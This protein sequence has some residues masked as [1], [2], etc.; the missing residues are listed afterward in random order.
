MSEF[1]L[2][3]LPWLPKPSFEL[4]AEIAAIEMQLNACNE[5]PTKASKALLKLRWLATHHLSVTESFRLERFLKKV[6]HHHWQASGLQTCRL[7]IVANSTTDLLLGPLKIAALRHGIALDLVNTPYDQAYAMASDE[8]SPLNHSG[9]DLI[10]LALDQRNL[11]FWPPL[12]ESLQPCLDYVTDLILLLK[13]NSGARIILQ[14]LAALPVATIGY[15]PC[16][17]DDL[18]HQIGSFNQ[19][20]INLAQELDCWVLDLAALTG[21]VGQGR[22]HSPVQWCLNKQPFAAEMLPLYCDHVARLLATLLGL[23]RRCLVLDLDNTLWGGVIGDDGLEGLKMAQGDPLGEAH[24]RVQ[25]LAISLKQAGVIL[26]VSSKNEAETARL[27]FQKHPDMLLQEC[28]IVVFEASWQDKATQLQ[29]IAS[30]LGMPLH[31]LV[32]LDD[33][34]AERKQVRDALPEVAVPELPTDPAWFPETLLAAGYFDGL[35]GKKIDGQRTQQYQQNQQ[36]HIH[37]QRITDYSQYLASL[38]MKLQVHAFSRQSLGRVAQ[39]IQRSNQFNLTTRRYSESALSTLLQE[40][41]VVTFQ[42][43]LTDIFG[44]NGI[45]S[46]IICRQQQ[47][48]WE[49]DSW[50]MSCRVLKR[51]VEEALFNMLLSEAKKHGISRL[52]G[53]YI[54]TARNRLVAELYPQLGFTPLLGSEASEEKHTH[55]QLVVETTQ[56]IEPSSS[57]PQV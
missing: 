23:D 1:V 29:K 35:A 44:D 41:K 42:A 9:C 53:L 14:T 7:G 3:K 10:L 24:Q 16:S 57:L 20:L 18:N 22:W 30:K 17:I 15:R 47:Q 27:P 21:L 46:I 6:K 13:K 8:L 4:K 50:L 26:A 51:R 45:I 31:Q 5:Y 11:P 33:N 19:Q 54:P 38:Q 39:L 48:D 55:W 28:D 34:P 12:R 56:P 25:Q 36:R 2:E 43:T 37:R 32:L 40:P 49:I 52:I